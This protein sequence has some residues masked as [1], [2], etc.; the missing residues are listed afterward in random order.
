MNIKKNV[1]MYN[2]LNEWV[3]S[4][5][6][7]IFIEGVK[8]MVVGSLFCKEGVMWLKVLLLYC[9]KFVMI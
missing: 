3:V 4:L 5:D 6:L 8:L 1:V 9:F 2:N 7:K